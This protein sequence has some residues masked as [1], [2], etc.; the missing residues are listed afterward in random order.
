MVGELYDNTALYDFEKFSIIKTEGT[1]WPNA[2][3]NIIRMDAGTME[4]IKKEMKNLDMHLL[5]L[6]YIGDNIVADLRKHGFFPVEQWDLMYKD[7]LNESSARPTSNEYEPYLIAENELDS[8]I[9]VISNN[10]FKSKKL[11]RLIFEALKLNGAELVGLKDGKDLFGTSMIY[12]DRFGQPGI[13][14][15]SINEDQRRKGLAKAIMQF[16]MDRIKEKF[17]N[18]CFLQATKMAVPLYE[19]LGFTRTG[20]CSLFWKIK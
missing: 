11:D 8:W 2:A 3:F 13:Y 16:C 12:Y 15:V 18:I 14:M 20:I 9:R 1:E 6:P 7:N 19:S 4:E 5:I 17:H 10:L